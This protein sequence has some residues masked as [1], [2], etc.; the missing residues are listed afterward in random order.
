MILRRKT[1]F[2]SEFY[3]MKKRLSFLIRRLVTTGKY[4]IVKSLEKE[5]KEIVPLTLDCMFHFHF[6]LFTIYNEVLITFSNPNK[7]GIIQPFHSCNFH[8]TKAN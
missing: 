4:K 6:P 2:S 8:R 1:I 3:N 7:F 5:E